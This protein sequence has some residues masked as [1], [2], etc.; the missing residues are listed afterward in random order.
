MK[1]IWLLLMSLF[2]ILWLW[3][4]YADIILEEATIPEEE[5][6]MFDSVDVGSWRI[7]S[8]NKNSWRIKEEKAKEC[9]KDENVEFYVL[10]YDIDVADISIVNI[11]DKAA[12]II[13]NWLEWDLGLTMLFPYPTRRES[14]YKVILNWSG[15]YEVKRIWENRIDLR[16]KNPIYIEKDDFLNP[17]YVGEDDFLN[18]EIENTGIIVGDITQFIKSLVR[19]VIVETLLLFFIVKLCRKFWSI[20]NRK[21]IVTWILAS[22]VTL[23][24]LWFVL[25]IFF[26]NYWVYA[27]FWEIFVMIIE[28][29]IIKYSLKIERKMAIFASVVCNLSSFFVWLFIF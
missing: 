22:T 18:N 20:K 27:I 23:P 9:L 6:I 19:T 14:V 12:K 26:N 8:F 15:L 13:A 25:P 21:I 11:E 3:T 16:E 7:I 24:L 1:K 28:T 5:C 17:I 29:F 2:G 10:D 4:V